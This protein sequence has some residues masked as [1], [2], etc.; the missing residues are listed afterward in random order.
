MTEE[1]TDA[2]YHQ[3]VMGMV[4]TLAKAIESNERDY[5][6]SVNALITLLA[7]AGKEST[8]GQ[9]EYCQHVVTQLDHLMSHMAV[10]HH[11][12]Q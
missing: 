8:M 10:E 1:I 6:V 11:S 9:T 3:Q 2:Q 5:S 4:D 7:L 12:I